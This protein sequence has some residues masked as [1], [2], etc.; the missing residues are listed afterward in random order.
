MSLEVQMESQLA[1]RALSEGTVNCKGQVQCI[2]VRE[3][4]EEK[5]H[6]SSPPPQFFVGGRICVGVSESFVICREHPLK[7]Y[8]VFNCSLSLSWD[9][10]Y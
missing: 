3:A 1:S 8:F 2:C 5:I 9:I 4:T 6:H 10:Y 7:I